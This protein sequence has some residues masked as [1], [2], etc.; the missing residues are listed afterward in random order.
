MKDSSS[1]GTAASSEVSQAA[2]AYLA[3]RQSPSGGFCFY[4]TEFLDQPNLA[5]TYCA[6]RGLMLLG[7]SVQHRQRVP[8]FLESFDNVTQPS[9]NPGYL[10]GYIMPCRD[11]VFVIY[12]KQ[13]KASSR[14]TNRRPG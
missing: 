7:E 2:V 11:Q 9:A 13:E 8:S 12:C 6:V 10:A 1:L 3:S 14:S 4:R 5:D